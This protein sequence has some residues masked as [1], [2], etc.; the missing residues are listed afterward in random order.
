MLCEIGGEIRR[1]FMILMKLVVTES[2][3]D[4]N[5]LAKKLTH[6]CTIIS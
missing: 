2:L 5:E 6:L 4:Q 1:Y 3:G